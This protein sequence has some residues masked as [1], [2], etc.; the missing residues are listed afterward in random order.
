MILLGLRAVF[1]PVIFVSCLIFVP[2]RNISRARA[3][4]NS[5]FLRPDNDLV[6]Q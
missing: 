3:Y 4:N 1:Q 5:D 2:F 6:L